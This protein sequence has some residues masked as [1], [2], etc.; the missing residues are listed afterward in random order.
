MEIIYHIPHSSIF[1]P[2]KYLHEYTIDKRKLLENAITL[3][4]IRTD[5][6]ISESYKNDTLIFPY[7]RLFCDVERFDS[8]HEVMNKK[9]MGVLY[10]KNHLLETIRVNPTPEIKNYYHTHHKKLNDLVKEKLKRGDVLIFDIHS[11]SNKKL[12]Y[13]S[14]NLERPDVCIGINERYSEKMLANLISIISEFGYSYCI[15][16]PFSGCLLPSNYIDNKRVNGFMIEI[17]KKVYD[18]D[19]KFKKIQ[20]ML[21]NVRTI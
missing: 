4:D 10:S 2:E 6:M 5:E 15:N 20:N 18:N 16:E 19:Q 21:E 13:E 9:G 3:C 17:N 7:S 12:S 1:I 14:N 11:F 8:E